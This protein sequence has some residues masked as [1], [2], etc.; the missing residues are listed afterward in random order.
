MAA[1]VGAASV[2]TSIIDD[3]G[4]GAIIEATLDCA[5]YIDVVSELPEG[6]RVVEEVSAINS[7]NV[8]QQGRQGTDD[9]PESPM[10]FSKIALLVRPHQSFQVSV[11]DGSPEPTRIGW[12]SVTSDSPV[13]RISVGPCPGDSDRWLVFAGGVS[14]AG[15]SCVELVFQSSNA[16]TSVWLSIAEQCDPSQTR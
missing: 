13:Q 1:V 14:V 4:E 11:G 7:T 6:F 15:P 5:S 2:V 8:H 10:R 16:S 9:D 12:S 3:S